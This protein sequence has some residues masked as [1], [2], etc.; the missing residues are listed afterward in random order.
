MQVL[1]GED[2]AAAT[3][4]DAP[5]RAKSDESTLQNVVDE[6]LK[7]SAGRFDYALD[8]I[9][10]FAREMAIS[11]Q[12]L[13]SLKKAMGQLRVNHELE[14]EDKM[15]EFANPYRAYRDKEGRTG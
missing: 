6:L 12:F 1:C 7:C 5:T 11:S 3:A 8:L 10:V 13:S 4:T 15:T 14:F 9:G 2:A